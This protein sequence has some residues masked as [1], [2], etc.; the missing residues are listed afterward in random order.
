MQKISKAKGRKVNP[1][2]VSINVKKARV[3]F[4]VAALLCAVLLLVQTRVHSGKNAAA[5]N[6]IL[7]LQLPFLYSVGE[8]DVKKSTPQAHNRAA[9]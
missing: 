5:T 2:N 3:A 8:I 9:A 4:L 7:A 6:K 1:L